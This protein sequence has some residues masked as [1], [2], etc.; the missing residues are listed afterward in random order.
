MKIIY[1]TEKEEFS[2]QKNK[3]RRAFVRS[4]L[5]RYDKDD[6]DD[7]VMEKE[8]HIGEHMFVEGI[9]VCSTSSFL[10]IFPTVHPFISMEVSRWASQPWRL[11]LILN[12]CTSIHEY[13]SHSLYIKSKSNS[14]FLLISIEEINKQINWWV[15]SIWNI[16]MERVITWINN[17][18][19]SS[20]ILFQFTFLLPFNVFDSDML[21]YWWRTHWC[22][23]TLILQLMID[24]YL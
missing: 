18:L 2:K 1:S 3:F 8:V 5:Q 12:E 13:R 24:I 11:S 7:D 15:S 4:F 17:A 23:M 20:I 19:T 10:S 21:N 6:S 16:V 9:V 14:T 22:S